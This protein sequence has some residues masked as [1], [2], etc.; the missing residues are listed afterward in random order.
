MARDNAAYFLNC[1]QI[2]AVHIITKNEENRNLP[3]E[4]NKTLLN[5]PHTQHWSCFH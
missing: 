2:K 4:T 3:A 5:L 1:T